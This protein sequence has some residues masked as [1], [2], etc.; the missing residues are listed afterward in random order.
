VDDFE[1]RQEAA[2]GR[3]VLVTLAP[4]VPG[5]L[6][7]V[8]HLVERGVRVSIGHSNASPEEIRRAV[9]AGATLSTHLGNGCAPN[10]AR[11]PNLIW[12]QLAADALTAC[13]IADGHH[14]PAATLK[15]M[16][17][18]KTPA[19]TILVTDATAGAA[20]AAGRYGLGETEIERD[21]AGRVT[22]P[23]TSTLAGSA[24]T[25][26]RAVALT[27]RDT[28]LPLEEVVAMASTRPATYLGLS[29]AGRA[30]ADWD[31]ETG[32]LAVVRVE[33]T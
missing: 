27:V 31:P 7:L 18:A 20:A 6:P 12:E 11:H 3:I 33:G 5:A 19:R 16:V 1:R 17:R 4:E 21:T 14:L 10:L 32:S 13:F 30:W 28:G 25:L 23:G 29:P 8:G 22:V 2:D 26:D 9:Q 24:L 15:S